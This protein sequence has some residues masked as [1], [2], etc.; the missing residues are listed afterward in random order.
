MALCQVVLSL[1]GS[2]SSI[3]STLYESMR[4]CTQ[5]GR[6]KGRQVE[7]SLS[8]STVTHDADSKTSGADSLECEQL[9]LA[10]SRGNLVHCNYCSELNVDHFM[11]VSCTDELCGDRRRH[12]ISCSLRT[13]RFKTGD[14]VPLYTAV[15][16][17]YDTC[18]DERHTQAICRQYLVLRAV[19]GATWSVHCTRPWWII[20]RSARIIIIIII[21]PPC[22]G[23][24]C[25]H[26]WRSRLASTWTTAHDPKPCW[27]VLEGG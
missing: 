12:H 14:T 19:D 13:L 15:H 27:R 25:P 24:R 8:A 26:E 20:A 10:I 7:Y 1:S 23:H 6:P 3:K 22:R 18:I 2:A 9:V 16:I 5:C 4:K 17:H 21:V 11:K